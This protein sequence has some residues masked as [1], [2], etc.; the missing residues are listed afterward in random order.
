MC[1]QHLGSETPMAGHMFMRPVASSVSKVAEAA[2]PCNTLLAAQRGSHSTE[3]FRKYY[4]VSS[5]LLRWFCV[6][7]TTVSLFKIHLAMV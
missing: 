7:L 5:I 4:E 3:V 2:K 1:R 6:L